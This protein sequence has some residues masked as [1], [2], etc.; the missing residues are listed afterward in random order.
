MQDVL[1]NKP[2]GK[3]YFRTP[4]LIIAFLCVGPFMLPLVWCNPHFSPRKKIIISVI[5]AILTYLLV[6]MMVDSLRSINKYYRLM[7]R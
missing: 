6:V 3:W 5:I 1:D 2:K 4:T 7:L